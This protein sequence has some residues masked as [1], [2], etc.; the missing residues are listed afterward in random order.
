MSERLL[1]KNRR[2]ATRM[3]LTDEDRILSDN[4]G[5][6]GTEVDR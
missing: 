4:K 1:N 6:D 3:I 5:V 2:R